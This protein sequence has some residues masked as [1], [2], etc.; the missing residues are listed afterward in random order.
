M[1]AQQD[2][3]TVSRHI[4]FDDEDGE[5]ISNAPDQSPD[6]VDNDDEQDVETVRVRAK[7]K[8]RSRP[9]P[10][11][12]SKKGSGYSTKANRLAARLSAA[13]EA[14]LTRRMWPLVRHPSKHKTTKQ[15]PAKPNVYDVYPATSNFGGMTETI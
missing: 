14:G 9:T 7:S 15:L 13:A 10:D 3:D 11:T 4:L 8:S 1:T 6:P 5:V 2:A 12:I